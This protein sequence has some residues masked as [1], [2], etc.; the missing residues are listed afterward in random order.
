MDVIKFQLSDYDW[1]RVIATI[2]GT[3]VSK[4]AHK[5]TSYGDGIYPGWLYY[6]LKGGHYWT[7]PEKL[8][9]YVE[10]Y[11]PYVSD[12]LSV[13]TRW[14]EGCGWKCVNGDQ[15]A[16]KEETKYAAI[17]G[18]SCGVDECSHYVVKIT[19]T[20]KNVIWDDAFSVKHHLPNYFH[21]EFD[22]K[23]YFKEV[24]KLIELTLKTGEMEGLPCETVC[25]TIINEEQID[26]TLF[27]EQFRGKRK[28]FKFY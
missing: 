2:N 25:D 9:G 8:S 28:C 19:E 3:K 26:V 10:P 7:C 18:C 20:E 14:C 12:R 6:E 11:I 5:P 27:E 16:S 13:P 24:E 21:F 4:F 23:Q 1:Y 15:A 22:K 17:L